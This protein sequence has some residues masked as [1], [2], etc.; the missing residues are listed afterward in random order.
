MEMGFKMEDLHTNNSRCMCWYKVNG[1]TIIVLMLFI[2]TL[3]RKI[4]DDWKSNQ[5]QPNYWTKVRAIK[6]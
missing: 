1:R 4:Y 3:H 6:L 5:C 2:T